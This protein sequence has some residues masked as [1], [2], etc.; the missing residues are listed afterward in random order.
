MIAWL[1]MGCAVHTVDVHVDPG[2]GT[3]QQVSDILDARM[4]AV[5]ARR[6]RVTA[7]DDVV[8]TLRPE[9]RERFD[10][11]VEGGT[12]SIGWEGEPPFVAAFAPKRL[13]CVDTGG[14][15]KWG[16]YLDSYEAD[17]LRVQTEL[18]SGDLVFGVDD[19]ALAVA[20]VSQ[21]ITGGTV[22]VP[23]D[24]SYRDCRVLSAQLM[25]GPLPDGVA[26]K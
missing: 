17:S 23:L 26:V 4:H 18:N 8:V 1:L 21:P 16:I 5:G 25:G 13:E 24:L 22:L 19:T 6:Y 12:M 15:V 14:I 11:I 9:D 3:A 20:T 2:E 10:A 7:E